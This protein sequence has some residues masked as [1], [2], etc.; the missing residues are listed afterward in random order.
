MSSVI[1]FVDVTK[2]YY[3][4]DNE[5]QVLKGVTFSVGDNELIAVMGPSGSGKSTIMNIIGLLDNPSSGEYKLSGQSVADLDSDSLAK[6][7]NQKIGFVFQSFF[8]LP[9]MNAVQNVMLPLSYRGVVG[10]EAH[11]RAMT[12]LEKVSMDQHAKHKPHELSGGQ[13][14]RVAIARALVGQPEIILADE[15]TGA[16]DSRIGQ[17][18]MELFKSLHRDEHT[19]LIMITHD[20]KI[21]AQ[22]ERVIEIQDGRIVAQ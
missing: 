11:D 4:G 5:L 8:L 16:L 14:Q 10:R 12:M 15:P 2:T 21:G 13:Q 1:E 17:E 9:R 18:V 22:C 19:T 7:R 20:P 6:I 3:M